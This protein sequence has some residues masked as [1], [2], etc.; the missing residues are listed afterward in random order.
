MIIVPLFLTLYQSR[1][2]DDIVLVYFLT[3]LFH[4]VIILYIASV[5][6]LIRFVFLCNC[7][8]K[9][10]PVQYIF[11][12]LRIWHKTSQFHFAWMLLCSKI[13]LVEKTFKS[14]PLRFS[15]LNA[16]AIKRSANNYSVTTHKNALMNLRKF[17]V[18]LNTRTF[19]YSN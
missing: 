5:S 13:C 9:C 1:Y 16:S 8:W 19:L 10:Y 6:C 15:L 7:A 11:I 14:I 17:W 2:L 3:G 12:P 4:L 18:S